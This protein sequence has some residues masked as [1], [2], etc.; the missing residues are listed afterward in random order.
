MINRYF[1]HVQCMPDP[2]ASP[3]LLIPGLEFHLV[4]QFEAEKTFKFNAYD[5]SLRYYACFIQMY[6]HHTNI[7]N[8]IVKFPFKL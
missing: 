6:R 8:I 3:I 1:S 7:H 4:C 5:V 2:V